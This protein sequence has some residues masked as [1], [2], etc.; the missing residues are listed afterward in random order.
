MTQFLP[1]ALVFLEHV[2]N[3]GL[4]NHQVWAPVVADYF[5]A[6]LV[7]P[8]DDAVHFF[9]VA[10]HNHHRRSRLHLLLIIKIL[11]VG[12]L[13]RSCFSTTTACSRAAVAPVRAPLLPVVAIAS[14]APLCQLP[15]VGIV[16]RDVVIRNV[17]AMIVIHPG[18]RRTD[19]LAVGIVLFVPGLLD[20]S[21]RHG[22]FHSGV[23]AHAF[24]QLA[25][26]EGPKSSYEGVKFYLP[27]HRSLSMTMTLSCHEVRPARAGMF[28]L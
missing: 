4:V 16:I 2:F 27:Y 24:A 18:Q 28:R 20:W 3:S 9:A 6:G 17:V 14:V 13:W 23:P 8:F 21:G 25:K 19:Q 5:D 7:V 15:M 11:G 22:F 1:P 12:L 10:Q 26:L